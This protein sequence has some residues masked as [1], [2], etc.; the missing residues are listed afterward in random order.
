M[1]VLFLKHEWGSGQP[2]PHVAR[3]I[4]IPDGEFDWGGTCSKF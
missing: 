4:T 3:L 1:N 2:D